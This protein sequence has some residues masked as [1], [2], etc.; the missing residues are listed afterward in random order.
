MM[1]SVVGFF[2]AVDLSRFRAAQVARLS[3]S[4]LEIDRAVPARC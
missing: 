1:L 2:G 3:Y 4:A